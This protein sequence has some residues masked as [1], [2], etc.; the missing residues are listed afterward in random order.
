MIRVLFWFFLLSSFLYSNNIFKPIFPKGEKVN[1]FIVNSSN[2]IIDSVIANNGR[3][4]ITIEEFPSKLKLWDTST[5]RIFYIKDTKEYINHISITENDR[6]LVYCSDK[7]ISFFDL[8]NKKIIKRLQSTESIKSLNISADGR[9]LI[10]TT[11][12]K[13][14]LYNIKEEKFEYFFEEKEGI[15]K[16]IISHKNSYILILTKGGKSSIKLYDLKTSKILDNFNLENKEIR[17][18]DISSDEQSIGAIS[19]ST[20]KLIDIKTRKIKIFV[21]GY[22]DFFKFS[23]DNKKVVTFTYNKITVWD[24]ETIKI[25]SNIPYSRNTG[26]HY[27]S[28]SKDNKFFSIV[29]D[30][31]K[32]L[33]LINLITQKV[34]DFDKFIT[35]EKS[36][37][38]RNKNQLI[39]IDYGKG[40]KFWNLN[41]YRLDSILEK[42]KAI[43]DIAISLN[44]K[45]LIYSIDN[46]NTLKVIDLSNKQK[47]YEYKDKNNKIRDV[48][49]NNNAT[50]IAYTIWRMKNNKDSVVI[51]DINQSKILKKIDENFFTMRFVNIDKIYMDSDEKSKLFDI[52][53]DKF[54]FSFNES[55]SIYFY[56][57]DSY[58]EMENY[59]ENYTEIKDISTNKT[60]FK[61]LLDNNKTIN[62]IIDEFIFI[63]ESNLDTIKVWNIKKQKY[64]NMKNQIPLINMNQNQIEKTIYIQKNNSWMIIDSVQNR[65]YRNTLEPLLLNSKTFQPITFQKNI[66]P[67]SIDVYMQENIKLVN[68]S[69]SSIDIQIKNLS[70]KNLYWI[71]PTVDDANFTITAKAISILK[72]NEI[73]NIK[74]LLNYNDKLEK[75][76]IKE[77]KLKIAIGGEVVKENRLIANVEK[78]IDIAIENIQLE[79]EGIYIS[80]KK[81][82]DA[83]LTNLKVTLTE[84]N[85]SIENH[86]LYSHQYP[87]IET[88][89]SIKIYLPS[90]G[91]FGYTWGKGHDFTVTIDADEIKPYIFTRYI[92][93]DMPTTIIF[94]LFILAFLLIMIPYS[95]YMGFHNPHIRNISFDPR[96]I[97]DTKLKKLPYYKKILKRQLKKEYFEQ[98]F[99]EDFD[100]V[101]KFFEI[102]NQER[103]K[104]FAERANGELYKLDSNFFEIILSSNFELSVESFLLYFVSSTDINSTFNILKEKGS[105]N[106]IIVIGQTEEEQKLINENNRLHK[107]PYILGISPENLKLFLLKKGHTKTLSKI[108]ATRMDRGLLS[109]YQE[110][111]QLKN[112]LYFFGREKI[113]N[114]IYNRELSNYFIVGA[115][116]I[117]KSSLLKALELKFDK[118]EDIVCFSFADA[119]HLL[120]D[121]ARALEIDKNSSLEDIEFFIADSSKKYLFLID[122]VDEFVIQE[123]N[124]GYKMLHA[125]RSLTQKGKA[126]FIM[127]GYYELFS[128]ISFDYHSPIKNFGETVR[129]GKL[130]MDAC[131]K[132]LVEPMD[133]LGLYYQDTN[134]WVKIIVQTGQRANL[135]AMVCAD[136]IKNLKPF[137][138]EITKYDIERA[139]QC[140]KVQ[141]THYEWN[142]TI[143]SSEKQSYITQIIVYASV[144]VNSFTLKDVIEVFDTLQISEVTL[145]EITDSLQQLELMY[146]IEK[147]NEKFYRYTIPL[148]QNEL[149][150][151]NEVR[152]ERVI[153]EF[154]QKYN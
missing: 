54:I 47:I 152:L 30:Y 128:Q 37:Y 22:F 115:R 89:S 117:G 27:F 57:N 110:E 104:I 23:F 116:Q 95:I 38:L 133:N 60:V 80:F 40:I 32:N 62:D 26:R 109:P 132:L 52:G 119:R 48:V 93:F 59:D 144:V 97:F 16:L 140:S 126:Y 42:N 127:A 94:P 55:K 138:N 35:L 101:V 15:K 20:L 79:D 123:K 14:H 83:N 67:K 148:M 51:I 99:I 90:Q 25:L 8:K 66:S 135:V 122:E 76:L 36:L 136:I 146:I 45:Y 103:A 41:T 91:V 7:N 85:Q 64:Q 71:E 61:L 100:T 121:M 106:P 86:F 154:R 112:E 102:D 137:T 9:Y 49:I 56:T 108:F 87:T 72:P 69:T 21:E 134:N 2:R 147:D 29:N 141:N 58:Y 120:K 129:L 75:T 92:N 68:N 44:E 111:G 150:K 81:F 70:K 88:K 151:E 50:K 39:S 1:D 34:F 96:L 107:L 31:P 63:E 10:Y 105:T 142:N 6:L 74:I 73:K 13:V 11:K 84:G 78:K 46:N 131:A 53:K 149:R 118:R 24:K 43:T 114:H 18:I 145:K 4:I 130:E 124:S 113:I 77:L 33:S 139:L 28:L 19:L 65:L 5:K 153:R 125:F 82:I 17:D 3:F 12:K 98:Y 143:Y